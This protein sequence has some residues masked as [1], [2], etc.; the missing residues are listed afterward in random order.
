MDQNWRAVD[1]FAGDVNDGV[2]A[3]KNRLDTTERKAVTLEPGVQVVHAEKAAPFSLMGLSGRTLVNLAGRDW[4]VSKSLSRFGRFQSTLDIDTQ[5]S[6][7]GSGSLKITAELANAIADGFGNTT[8]TIKAGKKYI[9]LG[10]LYNESGSNMQIVIQKT[11]FSTPLVTSKNKWEFTYVAFSPS[12]DVNNIQAMARL[13]VTAAGQVGYA[14]ALRLYEISDVE[15]TALANMTAEQVATKYPYVDS[16]MPV[17]NPYAIRY[18]EN[19]LPSIYEAENTVTTGTKSI[20]S[21]YSATLVKSTSGFSTFAWNISIVAGQSYTLAMQVNVSGIGGVVG[22]GGYYNIRALDSNGSNVGGAIDTGPYA[23]TNGTTTLQQTFTAP[24]GAV[25]LR[26]IFG[27]DI[28]TF[29]TFSFSNLMLN[30]GSIAKP[31]KLRGDSM[32]ALQADLYADPVTG[33]NADTVFEREGQYFKAK[34]WHKVALDGGQ[35][36]QLSG[37]VTGVKEVSASLNEPSGLYSTSKQQI[38]KYDGK[39]LTIGV[40]GTPDTGNYNGV[41]N[42]SFDKKVFISI[43]TNDS[44]W[45]DNY[46]PTADEIK[47]YFLGWNMYYWN[48]MTAEI[49]NNQGPKSWRQI[50]NHGATTSILPTTQVTPGLSKDGRAVYWEPYRLVYQLATPTVEPIVSEGQ[51]SFVEGDNQ[52]EVGTGIVLRESAKPLPYPS[53]VGRYMLNY[54]GSGGPTNPLKNKPRSIRTVYEGNEVA[55]TRIG[56]TGNVATDNWYG[57]WYVD[58]IYA[59]LP[60]KVYSVTY[61]MLDVS[62]IT[63][64]FGSYA[65]NEKTLLLDLVDSVQ[66]NTAR[67][68]VLENKKADRD[69]PSWIVPTLLNGWM[70]FSTTLSQVGYYKDSEGYVH[71]KGVL[72][73]GTLNVAMFML[74]QGY[75]PKLP[76][77]LMVAANV[78]GSNDVLGRVNISGNGAV[79]PLPINGISMTP[80]GWVSLDS[81]PPFLAEQ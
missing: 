20:T 62:P 58:Y 66:Q 4:G 45:G 55:H 74:P 57:G 29:G 56:F 14:D 37:S 30:I 40:G 71:L 73:L 27:I 9:A 10:N 18:G 15:Y 68:S 60:E 41:D 81:V 31:F 26:V 34:K 11:G 48:G 79:A 77:V 7:A 2:N 63:P 46:T 69:S 21:P 47:A 44:G 67:V 5:K 80:N 59:Y 52:V 25:V 13:N 38:V 33:A 54:T 23:T 78:D 76:L 1:D 43:F 49:F 16:V 6:I 51:L 64:F 24:Q 50:N 53:V 32:L 8:T 36:W 39:I 70:N 35:P 3:I 19:L 61:F 17:R 42:P 72:K 65:A 75:R 12:V 28:G 22:T